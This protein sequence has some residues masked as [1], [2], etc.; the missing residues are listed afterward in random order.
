MLWFAS[1][2]YVKPI[3]DSKPELWPART[4]EMWVRRSTPLHLCTQEC[5]ERGARRAGKA[6][7]AQ[8]VLLETW[9][10][11]S[12][13]QLVDQ[14][15]THGPHRCEDAT[16][17]SVRLGG[18]AQ[19]PYTWYKVILRAKCLNS[20]LLVK[21]F[22]GDLN[23]FSQHFVWILAEFFTSTQISTIIVHHQL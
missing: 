10:Q 2:T 6:A 23:S 13:T 8:A 4:G 17:D 21:D 5:K 11:C 15:Q 1:S 7:A 20:M 19:T 3:S 18:G 22:Q 16:L 14:P 12:Q 9:S